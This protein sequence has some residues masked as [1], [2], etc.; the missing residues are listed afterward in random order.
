[1]SN[2]V[3]NPPHHFPLYKEIFINVELYSILA[4]SRLEE[5]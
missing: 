4:Y 1:M 3:Y 2:I 5:S